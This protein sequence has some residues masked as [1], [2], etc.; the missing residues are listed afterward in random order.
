[1][2]RG[3]WQ[4]TVHG[5][6]KSWTRLS[7][8]TLSLT[9]AFQ[10]Y[11]YLCWVLAVPA[12]RQVRDSHESSYVLWLISCVTWETYLLSLSPSFIFCK[13]IKYNPLELL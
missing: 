7:T 4:A 13:I 1:M 2:D 11:L 10:C 6:A 5:V 8:L 12:G 9:F 3:A